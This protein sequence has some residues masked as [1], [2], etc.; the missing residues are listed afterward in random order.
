M[1]IGLIPAQP[2]TD[3]LSTISAA[4]VNGWR[5]ALAKCLDV[6]GG[7]QGVASTPATEI[8]IAGEGLKISG[9]GDAARLK[10][11]ASVEP[12]L[13]APPEGGKTSAEAAPLLR[14]KIWA[15]SSGGRL[16]ACPAIS[17][18]PIFLK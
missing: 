6:V 3:N 17:A 8:N 11:A 14:T 5:A 2:A 15:P 7:S 10:Y 12:P 16:R 4:T 1:T 18:A 13:N 9:T